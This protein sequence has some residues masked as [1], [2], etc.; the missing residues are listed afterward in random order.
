MLDTSDYGDH[1]GT[2]KIYKR[3]ELTDQE[4][5]KQEG[6]QDYIYHHPDENWREIVVQFSS[7]SNYQIVFEGTIGS[8]IRSDIAIDDVTIKNGSCN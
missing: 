5:W 7:Q 1:M 8:G 4:I 2:L 3:T 6:S